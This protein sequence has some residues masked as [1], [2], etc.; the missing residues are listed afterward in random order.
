[1]LIKTVPLLIPFSFPDASLA[2]SK[3]KGPPPLPFNEIPQYF[4]NKLQPIRIFVENGALEEIKE[5][6]KEFDLE[7]R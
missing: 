3:P 2:S 6:T 1:M 4:S 5:F 7:G